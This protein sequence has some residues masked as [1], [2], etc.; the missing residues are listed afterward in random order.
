M[1]ESIHINFIDTTSFCCV[2]K[3]KNINLDDGKLKI[4]VLKN[5]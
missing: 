1:N 4:E 3:I 5:I 2:G